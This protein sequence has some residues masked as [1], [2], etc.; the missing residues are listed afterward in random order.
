[1]SDVK[2]PNGDGVAE[3]GGYQPPEKIYTFVQ[4][5]TQDPRLHELFAGSGEIPEFG[6]HDVVPAKAFEY[7]DNLK[8]RA[9]KIKVNPEDGRLKILMAVEGIDASDALA[10]STLTYG[11]DKN[12]PDV[13]SVR[14]RGMNHDFQRASYGKGQVKG[15]LERA[16]HEVEALIHL[17]V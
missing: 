1:M 3:K 6:V 9:D 5:E 16:G 10:L 13:D 17:D 14:H 8:R 15:A 4:I 12:S 7:L 2:Q 11:Q